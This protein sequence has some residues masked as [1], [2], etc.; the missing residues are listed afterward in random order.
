L[1]KDD[2]K[3]Q[4]TSIQTAPTRSLW[5]EGVL[6]FAT[7]GLYACVWFYLVARDL[8]RITNKPATPWLWIFVPLIVLAQPFAFYSL[9]IQLREVEKQHHIKPWKTYQQWLWSII[10]IVTSVLGFAL[11]E[12]SDYLLILL[13]CT[14]VW[15]INFLCLHRRMN[16]IREHFHTVPVA[17]RFAGYN[18]LEWLTVIIFTPVSLFLYAGI[19]VFSANISWQDTLD[20]GTVIGV[21]EY[22][23]HLTL[24]QTGWYQ[25]DIGTVTD[26]TASAEFQGP[27]AQQWYAFFI[28]DN[29]NNISNV[30]INRYSALLGQLPATA[31]CSDERRFLPGTDDL[32]ITIICDVK[33]GDIQTLYISVLQEQQ[34]VLGELLGYLSA[35]QDKVDEYRAAFIGNAKEVSF[36]E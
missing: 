24:T 15:M 6:L 26:G 33:D 28:Y 14:L 16:G 35:S 2:V 5:L 18:L 12:T 9:F 23:F 32:N 36:N 4:A 8:Q 17:E 3:P 7:F 21:D 13:P 31:V 19:L 29:D 30:A 10:Y 27:L 25:A 1:E 11:D 34:G 20:E 22:A